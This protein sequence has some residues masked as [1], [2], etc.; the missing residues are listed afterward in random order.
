MTQDFFKIKNELPVLGIGLGFRREL[1]TE[2][3]ESFNLIDWLEIVPENYMNI[4]GSAK[5]RLTKALEKYPIV[6][7]GVNLSIGSTDELNKDYLKELKA[8]L[9]FI[10]APWFSDHLCFTSVEGNYMHD[11]LPLPQ[12]REAIYHVCERIKRVQDYIERPLLLENISYYME[13]PNCEIEESQFLA[14]VLEQ[15]DCGLL[16]DVNNVYVNSI[17]LNFDP[18][19]YLDSLPLDRTVQM[20]VAGHSH[21]DEAIIDTH[22]APVIEPV[23]DL[24]EHVLK[25]V[26]VN[27]VMLERDQN[28]P[29]FE[30]ILGELEEIRTIADNIQPKLSAVQAERK[31]R[32]S[33]KSKKSKN[34]KSTSKQVELARR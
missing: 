34:K 18:Y 32:F 3:L 26:S 9:D 33:K 10:D 25:K 11:L 31:N 7:H 21:G 19:K 27:A 1:E 28:F 8:L 12:S 16:L 22:G 15:A 23:F 14:T 24:L 13:V 29:P 6:T 5:T 17:N 20:H 2:T 4:G 30:E